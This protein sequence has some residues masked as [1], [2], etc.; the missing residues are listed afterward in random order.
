MF[1]ELARDDVFR[2]E[3][4]RLWLRW[5]RVADAMTIARLAGEKAVAE[6]TANIPSP[7]SKEQ[8]EASIL[9]MRQSNVDGT[10]LHLTLSPLGQPQSVVGGISTAWRD[11]PDPVLGY[12]LGMP[13]W[14]SGLA[15]EAAQA[16][17][18]TRK[19]S[20]TPVNVSKYCRPNR[21]A[22]P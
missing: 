18:D 11:G 15:T 12:W 17:I 9:K 16:I 20:T 4:R 2:I 5:P 7:Y 14:G 10:G 21:N 3:T 13:H 6:N 22:V 1:P 19:T 8:A